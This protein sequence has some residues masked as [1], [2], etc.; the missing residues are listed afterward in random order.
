MWRSVRVELN[1]WHKVHLPPRISL[2]CNS[3][4][5][6]LLRKCQHHTRLFSA[7]PFQELYT[8]DCPLPSHRTQSTVSHISTSNYFWF[9]CLHQVTIITK[10]I[11]ITVFTNITNILLSLHNMLKYYYYHTKCSNTTNITQYAQILLF[12][13]TARQI[14]SD[15]R[16]RARRRTWWATI[17]QGKVL[18][19]VESYIQLARVMRFR[20]FTCINMYICITHIYTH[21]Y[22]YIYIYVYMCVCIYMYVSIYLSIYIYI[23]ICVYI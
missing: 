2:S 1:I 22:V 16:G 3:I 6:Q 18:W 8:V 21:M 17:C 23:C 9:V 5:R 19:G 4:P 13:C 7:R 14:H 20:G 15:R 11:H 10:Y 12:S